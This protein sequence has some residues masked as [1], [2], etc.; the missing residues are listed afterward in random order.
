MYA[1]SKGMRRPHLA[2]PQK[3]IPLGGG[4]E[5]S[6]SLSQRMVITDGIFIS[7]IQ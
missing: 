4:T 2:S 6:S 3:R 1:L 5:F 7:L